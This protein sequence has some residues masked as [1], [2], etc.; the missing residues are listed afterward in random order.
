M[1][2]E[3]EE[4]FREAAC[5]GDLETVEHLLNNSSVDVNSSNVIN[6][7]TA[8]HW[9]AK[10]N[11]RGIVSYLMSKGANNQVTCKSGEI[12]A[13]LSSD[14]EIHNILGAVNGQVETRQ[15]NL[16]IT[17]NYITHPEFPYTRKGDPPSQ[18]NRNVPYN[19]PNVPYN[20]PNT[21]YAGA[22][23]EIVLKVRLANSDERDFIEVELPR[24]HLTFES[25]LSLFCHELGVDRKLVYK[26]RKLPDTVVRKDKD[27]K[28]LRDYQEL[29]LVLSNKAVSASHRNYGIPACGVPR[30]EQILY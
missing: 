17:P 28:R 4:K 27:V 14:P 26:I 9:A 2:T 30:N 5:I 29:E 18:A 12:P 7:W 3:A 24:S 20:A 23:H 19:A 8:L 15:S 21:S 11:H 25:L 10:R 1:D 13:Q 6:G 22:E 16:P